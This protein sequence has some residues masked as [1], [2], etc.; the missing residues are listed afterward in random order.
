M[1]H[2]F[3]VL[4]ALAAL[5][6]TAGCVHI[7][8]HRTSPSVMEAA[9][10]RAPSPAVASVGQA[11]ARGALVD[12]GTDAK[13]KQPARRQGARHRPARPAPH[14]HPRMPVRSAPRH[15]T[16]PHRPDAAEHRHRVPRPHPARPRTPRP[17]TTDDMRT[18]C[19]LAHQPAAP[20][21]AGT[22]CDTYL[23]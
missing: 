9:T 12:T 4:T 19:R 8:A 11:P 20:A 5:L 21:E 15:R 17:G 18:V 10:V 3:R 2:Q 23:R 1:H 22:L 14:P 13:P 6:F 7:P 16:A